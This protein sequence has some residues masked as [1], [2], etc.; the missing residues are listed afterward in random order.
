[1]LRHRLRETTPTSIRVTLWP[2]RRATS[3]SWTLFAINR[4]QVYPNSQ[5]NNI[6]SFNTVHC[7]SYRSRLACTEWNVIMADEP[8]QLRYLLQTTEWYT[9]FSEYY[10]QQTHRGVLKSLITARLYYAAFKNVRYALLTAAR[11]ITGSL[12]HAQHTVSAA[13]VWEKKFS[14]S[15]LSADS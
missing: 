2:H 1:M 15:E 11:Q 6:R 3:D 10:W 8:Q 4:R 5:N 12:L 13:R 14:G 9:L 7:V